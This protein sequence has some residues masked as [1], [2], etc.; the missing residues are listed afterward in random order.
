VEEGRPPSLL[1]ERTHFTAFWPNEPTAGEF[2]TAEASGRSRGLPANEGGPPSILAERTQS[3]SH[4][5]GRE[6]KLTRAAGEGRDAARAFWPNEANSTPSVP[7]PG[8]S[9]G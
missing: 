3:T 1:A 5:Q 7:P 8:P 4:S 2:P 6:W 9:G